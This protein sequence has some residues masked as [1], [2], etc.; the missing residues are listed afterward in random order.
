MSMIK[1]HDRVVLTSAV[2]ADGLEAGDV[3]TVVH[4]YKDGLAY[5]VEFTTL[6]G[7]TA[8]VVTLE[9]AQLRPVGR[10]DITHAREMAPA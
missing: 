9:A 3:G 5:E 7:R 1:E 8:A 10:R 4:V 6:D 2:P